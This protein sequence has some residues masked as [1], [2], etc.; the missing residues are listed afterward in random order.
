M[1]DI[2]RNTGYDADGRAKTEA[3][4]FMKCPGCGHWFDMRD[5]SAVF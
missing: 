4:R 1:N 5:L 3:D 2:P